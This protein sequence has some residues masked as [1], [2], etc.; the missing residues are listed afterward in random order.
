LAGPIGFGKKGGGI[1]GVN[2]TTKKREPG[3]AGGRRPE[4]FLRENGGIA[5]PRPG[6]RPNFAFFRFG[7][8]VGG[9][10]GG[11]PLG[12]KPVPGK[13]KKNLSG[14]EG[15]LRGWGRGGRDSTATTEGF[16]FWP[17]VFLVIFFR[18]TGGER[19]KKK[20]N[21]TVQGGPSG[22]H[23][24]HCSR[25]P[26]GPQTAKPDSWIGFVNKVGRRVDSGIGGGG[27]TARERKKISEAIQ[28][29][30]RDYFG[31]RLI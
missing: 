27:P 1:S 7:K 9:G 5:F 25:R 8:S 15:D 30:P 10:G 11:Y 23:F 19:E 18:T 17:A 2:K 4:E 3:K 22:N 6:F 24:F 26:S 28:W 12:W 13:K 14:G 21:K 20:K 16:V 29:P 31:H